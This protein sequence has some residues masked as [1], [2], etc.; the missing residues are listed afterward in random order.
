MSGRS[1]WKTAWQSSPGFHSAV[2]TPSA[3]SC[4]MSFSV[5]RTSRTSSGALT[6]C[7]QDISGPGSR[8]HTSRFGR[9]ISSAVEFQ[10]WIS[11]IPTCARDMTASIESAT[12]YLPTLSS[13]GFAPCAAHPGPRLWRASESCTAPRC[14]PGNEPGSKACRPRCC[15][16]QR[17][18][19]PGVST[20]LDGYRAVDFKTRAASRSVAR[21]Q[22]FRHP[23]SGRRQGLAKLIR[24]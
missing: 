3:L 21:R 13:P 17:R 1:G 10:V 11:A 8:S 7:F 18:R 16:A 22:R 4:A 6:T 12:R 15:A 2:T 14:P 19:P 9:S 20:K 23:L 5:V 24:R